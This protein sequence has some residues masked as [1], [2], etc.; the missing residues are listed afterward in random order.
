[1]HGWCKK[2]A[3]AA[4]LAWTATAGSLGSAVAQTKPEGEM[5]FA[6]YVTMAPAWLDPG[7]ATPGF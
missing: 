2:L 1:M 7:E 6:L 3:V 4:V 5:R